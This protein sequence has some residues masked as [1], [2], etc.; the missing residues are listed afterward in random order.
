MAWT[1]PMTFEPN[2]VLT[3]AQ[4]NTHLRDNLLETAPSKA[5]QVGSLFFTQGPYRLAESTIQVSRIGDDQHLENDSWSDLARKGPVVTVTTRDRALVVLAC[6]M[7]NDNINGRI[8]ADYPAG[9][10][11]SYMGF[12]VKGDSD[13]DPSDSRCLQLAGRNSTFL[14]VSG[15]IFVVEDLEP[16]VNIFTAKY[17]TSGG[18]NG[19]FSDRF[20]GVIPL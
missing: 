20:L 14:T 13:I 11:T 8:A 18:S 3:A 19:E 5:T 2:A 6:R 17:K 7:G 10:G 4:L 16:G 15:C 9:E 1:S 12:E